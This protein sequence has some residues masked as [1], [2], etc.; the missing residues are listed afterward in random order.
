MGKPDTLVVGGGIYGVTTAIE[1]TARGHAVALID[2]GPLPHPLAA[3]TDISKVIR[4][5]YGADEL[6]TALGNESIDGWQRWNAEFGEELYHEAGILMLTRTP[7][8]PGEYEHDSYQLLVRRG[9]HPQRLTSAEIARRFPAWNAKLYTDGFFNPR[10]G[11]AESGRAVSRLIEKARKVGVAI[12]AGQTASEILREGRR[13][14]GVRTQEGQT[15]KADEVVVCAGAWT[16]VLIPEL[17]GVMRTP[18][19]PVFHLKPSDP[20]LF[21]AQVFPISI[22]DIAN[23]GWYG[24]PLHPRE[25]VVKF[26]HHGVGRPVHPVD[27]ERIVTREDE[28][29]LR[30]FLLLAIPPLA[31]AEVVYT[32]RCLYCDTPDTNFWIDHH[33]QIAGLTVAAGGSGHAF[34]FAPLLGGI[35]ADAVEGKPHPA[36]ERFRWREVAGV[37]EGEGD[38]ARSHVLPG[39]KVIEQ[40]DLE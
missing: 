27:G 5:E 6:Y 14:M 30:S 38:G 8:R 39:D 18:G 2:P 26:G 29:A 3:S 4:M 11:Y 12:H 24:F 21:E 19:M 35:I 13:A 22:G 32:R 34:K 20:S 33:P 25:Q 40:K 17:A 37:K 23:T 36:L 15:F 28:D 7:M 10:G 31:D 1:L 16:P 9:H